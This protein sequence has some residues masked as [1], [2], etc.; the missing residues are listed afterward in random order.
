MNATPAEIAP[1]TI[2]TLIDQA[3]A[4][5][6]SVNDY[7]RQLLGITGEAGAVPPTPGESLGEF[8]TDLE[9]LAEGTEHLPPSTLTYSREDI[10]FDHD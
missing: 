10:Y 7:L 2:Q 5:G 3:A 1:E 8:M 4:S 9:A 6:L